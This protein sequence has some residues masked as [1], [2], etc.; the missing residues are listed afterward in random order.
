MPCG[1]ASRRVSFRSSPDNRPSLPNSSRPRSRGS[2][3]ITADLAVLRRHG[4]DA[5]VD[6]RPRHAQP[7][8]AVLRQ[9]PLGDVE[10]GEN[11]DAR[12]Q[13][14]RQGSRRCRDRAQQSVDPHA[15]HEA[16]AERLDV[17][18][19][20]PQ[21]HGLFEKIVDRADDRRA[22]RQVAQALDVVVRSSELGGRRRGVL[23]LA[24]PLGERSGNVLER[25]DLDLDLAAQHDLGGPHR[26]HVGRIGHRELAA[27][28]GGMERKYRGLAQEAAGEFS[29]QRRRRHQLGQREPR[30][31]VELRHFVS[32]VVCR[33]VGQF[34]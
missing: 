28:I 21:L 2:R 1:S 16:V 31:P 27:A 30:Q 11:L 6:L 19:A 9:P 3:R 14:L 7:R 34:P 24:E 25:G 29:R 17:D 23:F 12:D 26:G 32:E 13:R 5:H 22:A 15:H 18:V 8:G 20:R 10:A 33:Q 4:G